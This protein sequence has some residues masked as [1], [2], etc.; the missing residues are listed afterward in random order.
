MRFLSRDLKYANEEVEYHL[1]TK[2]SYTTICLYKLPNSRSSSIKI[3][4]QTFSKV[5]FVWIV[6]AFLTEM[7]VEQ[8]FIIA[9]SIWQALRKLGVK[10]NA[11]TRFKMSY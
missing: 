3:C 1:N 7:V 8:F 10:L 4:Y 9:S 11:K 2:P 5:V 6:R